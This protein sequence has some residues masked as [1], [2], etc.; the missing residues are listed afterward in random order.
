MSHSISDI[1]DEECERIARLN[2]EQGL[3]STPMN[4]IEPGQSSKRGKNLKDYAL[5]FMHH[6]YEAIP[7]A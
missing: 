6:G 1:W 2:H 5:L 4:W 7:M 3:R